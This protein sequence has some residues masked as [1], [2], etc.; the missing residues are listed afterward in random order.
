MRPRLT[1]AAQLFFIYA[2][3]ATLSFSC[4]RKE[5]AEFDDPDLAAEHEFN[6]LK[7]KT[8]KIPAN[9]RK[10]EVEQA[11]AIY[12]RQLREARI[13]SNNYTLQ[14]PINIGG[15]TRCVAYDA[16]YNGTTNRVILAGGV[17]GGIYKSTDDGASWVR[18]SPTSAIY[19]VTSLAQ[20]TRAGHQDTWYYS[21]GEFLGSSED[22][23]AP[24]QSDGIFKSTDNG[25]TWT[26]LPASNTGVFESFDRR[27]DVIWRVIVNP[28]N[29]DI[30]MAALGAIY[31]SSNGGDTWEAV[32]ISSNPGVNAFHSTD[33]IITGSGKLYAAVAGYVSDDLDGVWTSAT[34]NAG[35]W[36]RIAGEGA[37]GSPIGWYAENSYGRIVLAAVPTNPDIVYAYVQSFINLCAGFS[38]A[39]L[40]KW[41]NSTGSWTNLSAN[42]PD[43][44]GSAPYIDMQG[45]YNMMI[46]VKP[47]D[48]NVI[49]LG[50]TSL[51]RSTDGFTTSTNIRHIGGYGGFSNGNLHPDT[52]WIVFKPGNPT[53]MIC[54]TDGGMALTD[55]NMASS[56]L[57]VPINDNYITTQFYHVAINPLKG[58]NKVIGGTQDNGTLGNTNGSGQYFDQVTGGDG[59][60][61]GY[62][63]EINGRTY[64]YTSYQVGAINRKDLT[65][66]SIQTITPSGSSGPTLWHTLFKLDDDNTEYVYMHRNYRLF[67]NVSASTATTE[68]WSEMTGVNSVIPAFT[69]I[70]ALT[71]TRGSY[72][73]STS[74]LFIGLDNGKLFRLDDPVNAGPLTVP[75]DI[76]APP[77][78]DWGYI[79]SIAV[80]PRN[81]DTVL[82]TRSS[83]GVISIWWTGNANAASPTWVNVERNL[84]L[85]SVRSSAIAVTANG[86]EYFVGTSVGLFHSANPVT[87]D[88]TQESPDGVG[89]AVVTS[90]ALRT[91]DNALLAGTYG[92][93]LW[94]TTLSSP[95]LPLTLLDFKGRLQ[96]NN[97]LLQ[98]KT[99]SESNT[100]GFEIQ[101]SYDGINFTAVGFVPAAGNSSTTINY[102]YSDKG[103]AALKNYYRLKMIDMDARYTISEVVIVKKEAS[104]QR[105][106]VANPFHN[107]IDLTFSKIFSKVEVSLFDMSGKLI[108]KER[109]SNTMHASLTFNNTVHLLGSGIYILDIRADGERVTVKLTKR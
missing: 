54:A 55:D 83:Y 30:Y 85:P 15:R 104:A 101:R 6:M 9:I 71:T 72:N 35:S 25:E 106:Y 91:S 26:K 33:I 21:T 37:G 67:R 78:N 3:I 46:H 73:P 44:T 51:Y 8:G 45:G 98:W 49:F 39:R 92:N 19:S 20:D 86:V 18:K 40:F 29:G 107:Q 36:T 94:T 100:S 38:R 1:S 2:M 89:N 108:G 7:D 28:N 87:S 10:Q 93:G 74:S 50:G 22:H 11:H 16:R 31:R 52:H 58:S 61:V 84:S 99:G 70:S 48:P 75:V 42:L 66:N 90:L 103:P 96:N 68:N 76:N 105:I 12:A 5:N 69:N 56:V 65:S 23:T 59:L 17:T 95:S 82:V 80:N 32:L 43:C 41:D 64:L 109:V 63:K 24:Y 77:F 14:G 102:Q 79:S 27:E 47:D 88:W 81:D 60:S 97:V 62:G 34:G 4:Q 53:A 57:W 13:A